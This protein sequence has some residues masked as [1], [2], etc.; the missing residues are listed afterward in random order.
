M[1]TGDIFDKIVY[2]QII[3]N[4]PKKI[5]LLLASPPCQGLSIAGKNRKTHQMNVDERNHLIFKV[6]DVM[7]KRS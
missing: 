7:I 5:K 4:S 3:D 2:R 1:I 6:F